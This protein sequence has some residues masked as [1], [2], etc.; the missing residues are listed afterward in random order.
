ME[1]IAGASAGALGYI[2]GNQS[3]AYKWA[4]TAYG[5]VKRRKILSQSSSKMAPIPV[6]RMS[7]PMLVHYAKRSGPRYVSHKP[8]TGVRRRSYK[9]S[10]YRSR[11]GRTT[12][13]QT[14]FKK[15]TRRRT[16]NKRK[17]TVKV[18]RSLRKKIKKV[19]NDNK[20]EGFTQETIA[21]GLRIFEN[22]DNIQ[23]V[24]NLHLLGLPTDPHFS[25]I[26]VNDAASV[27]W[28]EKL[29]DALSKTL[30]DPQSFDFKRLRVLVKD[31]SVTIQ[32]RNNCQRQL[33]C[34][35]FSIEPRSNN[36]EGDPL[37]SWINA[38][39]FQNAGNGANQSAMTYEQLHT[40]PGMLPDWRRNWKLTTSKIVL[41][42]GESYTYYEQGPKEKFYDF[43]RFWNGNK[44]QA[45]IKGSK[46][47]YV[48]YHVDQVGTLG[49]DTAN[50]T[51]PPATLP[52][53]GEFGQQ[54][55]YI[56]EVGDGK[57][58]RLN[59]EII[60]RYKL[61]MPELTG[62]AGNAGVTPTTT[63]NLRQFS[64]AVKTYGSPQQGLTTA[65]NKQNPAEDLT[66]LD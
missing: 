13:Y 36:T 4:R 8:Y 34:R 65:V 42:P 40:S 6:R 12:R 33:T 44:Y 52:G 47:I 60:A 46:F 66:G 18:S 2:H 43:Q 25:P 28:N 29:Q 15:V 27:L 24:S 7:N 19:V 53:T 32:F 10:S 1:Y 3:T 45:N 64:Y 49:P 39:A 23:M 5:A 38:L 37:N 59:F 54:G 30:S 17:R 14:P 57:A 55:R 26:R 48:A 51:P 21:G 31:S 62:L 9:R 22:G 41:E 20:I 35:I 58:H 50:P 56:D 63:L 61:A 11:R 16:N